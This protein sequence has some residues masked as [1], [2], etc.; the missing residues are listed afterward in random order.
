MKLK[1]WMSIILMS[2]C[3]LTLSACS[4]QRGRGMD[5]AQGNGQNASYGSGHQ[6]TV[7]GLGNESRFGRE[8]RQQQMAANNRNVYYFDF[9]SNVVRE[10]DKPAI[11]A[12][13]SK[14]VANPNRKIMLEGHTD[15]RGSREY[16]VGLGERRAQAV[17]DLMKQKGVDPSQIS[18]LSYGAQKLASTERSEEGYQRDR[19]AVIVTR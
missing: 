15:P 4:T 7:A 18:V 8:A 17:A 10:S 5:L 2:S 19:R 3:I 12:N 14:L 9:D 6:A 1:Q 11:E 16:N 13:S